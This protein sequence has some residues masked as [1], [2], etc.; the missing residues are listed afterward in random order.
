MNETRASRS[1]EEKNGGRN[2]RERAVFSFE[3]HVSAAIIAR[4]QGGRRVGRRDGR[5]FLV[6]DAA[7]F[8]RVRNPPQPSRGGRKG[9]HGRAPR[10]GAQDPTRC[11]ARSRSRSLSLSLSPSIDLS[12]HLPL[13]RPISNPSDELGSLL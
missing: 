4:C 12:P 1:T 13:C 6:G 5:T 8:S 7:I 10:I 11:R 3:K 9:S 2:G